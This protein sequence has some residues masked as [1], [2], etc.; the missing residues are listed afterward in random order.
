M[1]DRARFEELVAEAIDGLPS[2]V[3]DR[4][5]NVQV[6]VEDQPPRDIP[7][8][9]GLYEGIPLTE[10]G[11]EYTWA[12]P[13]RITLYRKTIELEA[14]GDPAAVKRVVADTVVHEIAHF[15]GISD[16]RLHELG[17]D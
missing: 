17:R 5:E 4:L 9:L 1:S 2:W 15:F 8:L 3:H 11:N 10:R 7:N 14:D 13:D 6:I 12:L 16:E